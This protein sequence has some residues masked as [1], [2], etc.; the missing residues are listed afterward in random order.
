MNL[1]RNGEECKAG[2][3]VCA[4]T[5]TVGDKEKYKILFSNKYGFFNPHSGTYR[6][7]EEHYKHPVTQFPE[8]NLK[9]VDKYTFELYQ[10]YLTSKNVSYM[11]LIR[12]RTFGQ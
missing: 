9:E 10:K 6:Q 2:E 5:T 8:Y 12:S 1:N 11:N 3:V 7:G 4:A